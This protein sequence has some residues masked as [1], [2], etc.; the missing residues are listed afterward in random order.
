MPKKQLKNSAK[1]GIA[2]LISSLPWAIGLLILL[3]FIR[4]FVGGNISAF[5]FIFDPRF[6]INVSFVVIMFFIFFVVVVHFSK[7]EIPNTDRRGY[8]EFIKEKIFKDTVR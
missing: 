6:Y 3:P 5:D 1:F 2:V 8:R 4:Y 7:L